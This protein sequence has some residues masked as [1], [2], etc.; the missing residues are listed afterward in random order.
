MNQVANFLIALFHEGLEINTIAQYR[1]AL[2]SSLPPIEGFKIGQN[3]A[4]GSLLKG[5][6][7][8]RPKQLKNVNNWSV[9]AVLL[10]LENWDE[11][12]VLTPQR[13]T[14]KLAMLLALTASN[15]VSEL[16]YLD[17]NHMTFLP[18]GICFQHTSHKKN[19]AN[20]KN[21][22]KSYFPYYQNNKKLCP[23]LCI[24]T[25]IERTNKIRN[26][27]ENPLFRSYIKPY[28]KVTPSTISRWITSCIK[29]AGYDVKPHQQM[30][31]SARGKSASKAHI[32][33]IPIIDILKAGDWK[34]KSTFANFYYKPDFNS[35]YG[36]KIL[37]HALN[38]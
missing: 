29:E 34:A 13:L 33:G 35:A 16:S 2:S 28:N 31:H 3:P 37:A 27:E 9:D 22:G 20:N 12:T 11:N 17:C 18:D 5:F 24:K 15:R 6:Q 4:I 25:Y 30:G 36:S 19:I 26:D 23:C 8:C 14:W 1:S 21:P 7:N 32:Q 10:M 38:N